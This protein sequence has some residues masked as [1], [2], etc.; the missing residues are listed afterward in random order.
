[1]VDKRW[2]VAH[3]DW[4]AEQ[5][6]KQ[7]YQG[8]RKQ[9]QVI[10]TNPNKAFKVLNKLPPAHQGKFSVFEVYFDANKVRKHG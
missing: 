5:I 8:K 6:V 4:S 9:E 7:V 2:V 10:L 1:M 3:N